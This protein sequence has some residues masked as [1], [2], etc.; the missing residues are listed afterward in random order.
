MKTILELRALP[1]I[2][3]NVPYSWMSKLSNEELDIWIAEA[4]QS[5]QWAMQRDGRAN[6]WEQNSE[7]YDREVNAIVNKTAQILESEYILS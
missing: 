4:K 6:N 7:N 5:A 2:N 3:W 1:E